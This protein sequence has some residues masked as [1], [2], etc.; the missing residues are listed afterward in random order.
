MQGRCSG[1]LRP[2][3]A[4]TSEALDIDVIPVALTDDGVVLGHARDARG[5]AVAVIS[6]PGGKCQ[7][8]GTARAWVPI[9]MTNPGQVIGW[10]SI[11]YLQR[12]WVRSGS[13]QLAWLPYVAEHHCVPVAI[14]NAGHIVGRATTD[15]C[16]HAL[17]WEPVVA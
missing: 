8:L 10:A 5:D 17:M 9:D 6:P 1:T 15:Q 7:L 3:N 2:T 14:N 16:A 13:G 11:E 12:P 4:A